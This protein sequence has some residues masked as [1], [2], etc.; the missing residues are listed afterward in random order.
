[1]NISFPLFYHYVECE[2]KW[3]SAHFGDQLSCMMINMNSWAPGLNTQPS[4]ALD[5]ADANSVFN[6]KPGEGFLLRS[7]IKWDKAFPHDIWDSSAKFLPEWSVNFSIT[8]Y[9]K[10]RTLSCECLI[11]CVSL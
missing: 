5:I 11:C 8:E 10:K 4:S 6:E 2:A 1:M 3:N 9:V 7:T